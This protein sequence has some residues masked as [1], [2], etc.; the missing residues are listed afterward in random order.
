MHIGLERIS[1]HYSLHRGM[2]TTSATTEVYACTYYG[3]G[4]DR[5]IVISNSIG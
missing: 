2:K 1:L 3:P 5:D 4:L